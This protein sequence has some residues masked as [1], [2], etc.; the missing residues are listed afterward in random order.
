MNNKHEPALTWV[1]FYQMVL[2]CM[3]WNVVTCPLNV[4]YAS[5]TILCDSKKVTKWCSI[6]TG[7]L[8]FYILIVLHVHTVNTLFSIMD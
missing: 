4:F 2:G 1:S 7:V 6:D 3:K 8:I 5:Y